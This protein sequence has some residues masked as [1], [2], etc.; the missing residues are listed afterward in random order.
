MLCFEICINCMILE[1]RDGDV[2]AALRD[3]IDALHI[4]SNY[5][6]AHL[7]LEFSFSFVL[8]FSISRLPLCV[9]L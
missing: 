7:R 8:I 6:K 2:Y 5:A 9:Y 1:N 4:E 3:C